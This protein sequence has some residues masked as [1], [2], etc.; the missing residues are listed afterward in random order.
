[1][2]K[3]Y[4]IQMGFHALCNPIIFFLYLIFFGNGYLGKNAITILGFQTFS[5]VGA[6]VYSI[7]IILFMILMLYIQ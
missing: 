7:S 5:P 1:M 2:K 4:I 3:H 6:N